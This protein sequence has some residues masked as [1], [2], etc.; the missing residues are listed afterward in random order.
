MLVRRTHGGAAGS[1]PVSLL[2]ALLL[3]SRDLW[4][5]CSDF[6][7]ICKAPVD[8]GSALKDNRTEDKWALFR[9]LNLTRMV[10]R[11]EWKRSG[12]EWERTELFSW[13]ICT[14]GVRE[15]RC[16]YAS[17]SEN[18]TTFASTCQVSAAALRTFSRW[19]LIRSCSHVATQA[20]STSETATAGPNRTPSGW[21]PPLGGIQYQ[22]I[23]WTTHFRIVQ[24]LCSL[25]VDL[26]QPECSPIFHSEWSAVGTGTCPC[27]L[28]TRLAATE[29]SQSFGRWRERQ[30]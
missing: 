11:M 14:P 21:A 24:T 15:G 5:S 4:A 27:T 9:K 7:R 17:R 28:T 20:T 23:L 22:F 1:R 10:S 18:L 25:Q 13:K 19:A 12:L 2:R 30:G 26:L 29:S 16:R 6:C 3:Y 8:M